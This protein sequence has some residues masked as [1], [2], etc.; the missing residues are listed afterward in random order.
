ML[1]VCSSSK[2]RALTVKILP[3]CCTAPYKKSGNERSPAYAARFLRVG[4]PA[5]LGEKH[6][7][8]VWAL[9]PTR[10]GAHQQARRGTERI[11]VSP[12]A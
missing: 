6:S 8:G 1:H 7:M 3:P 2:R 9:W 4:K 10:G 11:P 5:L 12:A